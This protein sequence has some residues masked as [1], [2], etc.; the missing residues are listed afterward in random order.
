[1]QEKHPDSYGENVLCN[2]AYLQSI[3]HLLFTGDPRV[4]EANLVRIEPESTFW[5]QSSGAEQKG[6]VALEIT[7]EKAAAAESG[8]AWGVAMNA[9]IPVM[10]LI[11]T[12][13]SMPYDIQQVRQVFGISS[14]FEKVTQVQLFPF[15]LLAEIQVTSAETLLVLC[16][17]Q[18]LS[19]SVGMITKSVLQEHLTTVA[20]SMTCTGDLHGFNNSGYKATCQSLKVQAPFME[21][22]LSVSHALS[23][24]L[25]SSLK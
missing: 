10:D 5:V 15:L 24:L 3:L 8:N 22:T 1:M 14:A 12:T 13:R 17:F 19:K 16:S 23:S 18:Y 2:Y 9:C 4:E 20:S 6:E 7:V 21:A 11:D 25:K